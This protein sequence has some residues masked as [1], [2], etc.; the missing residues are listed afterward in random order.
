MARSRTNS[1]ATPAEGVAA[2]AAQRK[3]RYYRLLYAEINA[4]VRAE[5]R[6][7]QRND[8]L[9][10]LSRAHLRFVA[11]EDLAGILAD[12]AQTLLDLT[13]S[14]LCVIGEMRP[15]APA[16]PGHR[17]QD[18]QLHILA[19]AVQG[20]P[21][22][23][24]YQQL[25]TLAWEAGLNRRT[26]AR[27]FAPAASGA[28]G[29]VSFVGL[30]FRIE[31]G[32]AGVLALVNRPEPYDDEAID[33]LQPAVS[34]CAQ[35]LA[36]ARNEQRRKQVELELAEERA[37][38]AQRVVERTAQ[39]SEANA[40]LARALRIKDEFLATMNHELRTPLNTMLILAE[41]L[42]QGVLG[43]LNEKQLENLQ[44]I[45]ESGRHLLALITEILDVVKINAGKLE[46]DISTVSVRALCESSLRMITAIADKKRIDVTLNV[47]AD[48]DDIDA[49]DRRLKQMLVNLLSNAV[50]FT[51][52]GGQAGLDVTGDAATNTVVFTVWDTGIGIA[53]QDMDKLFTP[54]AQIDSGLSRQYEGSGLELG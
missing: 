1:P 27:V 8:L 35:L 31:E 50:K 25:T 36:A 20:M 48:V 18:E 30:P 7:S 40:D 19:T 24:T 5:R 49:D 4:R 46:L 47:A 38:L 44:N 39:L 12:L 51:P 16:G 28:P 53:E 14:E 3:A 2:A 54:F 6:V 45:E 42:Q 41:V 13:G 29:V 52:E 9:N 11:H 26:A 22:D 33:L 37:S 15:G 43:P 32:S 10:A 21:H 23:A 34:T 17:A